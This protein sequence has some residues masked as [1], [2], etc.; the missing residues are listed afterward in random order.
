[1]AAVRF[2]N[3]ESTLEKIAPRQQAHQL[4]ARLEAMGLDPYQSELSRFLVLLGD[5]P[6]EIVDLGRPLRSSRLF[7]PTVQRRDIQTARDFE[8]FAARA[9][10]Q[11][12][13]F[14]NIGLPGQKAEVGGLVE[15]NR[16]FNRLI[17]LHFSELRKHCGFELLLLTIHPRWDAFSG[18]FDLHAHFI[19]RIPRNHREAA[20]RRLLVAFSKA[21]VGSDVPVRNAAACATYMIWGICP[22]E[23]VTMMPDDA[24]SDLWALSKAH[25]RLVRP[26]GSFKQFRKLKSDE[27]LPTDEERA[28]KARRKANRQETADPRTHSRGADRLLAKIIVQRGDASVPALLFETAPKAKTPASGGTT[29]LGY[30]S[31][32]SFITQAHQEVCESSH[33]P[34]VEQGLADKETHA[35]KA[36]HVP[37]WRQIVSAAGKR[38]QSVIAVVRPRIEAAAAAL[39]DL[40]SIFMFGD[41]PPP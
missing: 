4:A 11:D 12:W 5:A 19:C 30:S 3:P 14:W 25:A 2:E 26:G 38:L 40:M 22:Y 6:G 35:C 21:D 18:R 7:K 15:A 37:A 10:R 34:L 41:G 24:L 39:C 23:S 27:A 13:L 33:V 31:A 20:R 28:E 16:E 36:R 9:D 17:N 1:M 29:T 8:E 32:T